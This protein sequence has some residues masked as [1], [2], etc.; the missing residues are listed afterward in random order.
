MVKKDVNNEGDGCVGGRRQ[1]SI[2]GQTYKE[3]FRETPIKRKW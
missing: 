1:S 2:N 3:G